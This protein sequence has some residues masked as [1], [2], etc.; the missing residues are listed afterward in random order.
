MEQM[1]ITNSAGLPT[2]PHCATFEQVSRKLITVSPCLN[3][4]AKLSATDRGH[5]QVTASKGDCWSYELF[6]AI[7]LNGF[8]CSGCACGYL[9][10]SILADVGL[11]RWDVLESEFPYSVFSN[12]IMRD[13]TDYY[14]PRLNLVFGNDRQPNQA[15]HSTATVA[16]GSF[17]C[18]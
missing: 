7:F 11:H 8:Y 14:E 10:K 3:S 17:R 18:E 13:A 4:D 16:E 2:C 12:T 9:S 15:L 5:I 6:S 1:P